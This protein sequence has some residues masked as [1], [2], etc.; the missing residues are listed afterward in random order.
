MAS[1][2]ENHQPHS[3]TYGATTAPPPTPAAQT[4]CLSTNDAADTLSHFLHR[5]PPSL[6][7]PPRLS[8]RTTCPPSISFSPQNTSFLDPYLS[9]FSQLGFFQLTNHPIPSQLALSAESESLSLFNLSKTQKHQSFSNTWPLGYDEGDDNNNMEGGPIESFCFDSSCSTESTEV[10]SSTQLSL[11]S[12]QKFTSELEKVGTD[13]VEALSSAMG[14]SKRLKEKDIQFSSLMWVSE[15]VAGNKQMISGRFYPYII[16]LQYQ[17]T[18][19]KYSVLTDSGWSSV[20]PQVDSVLVTVGDIA[21]VWS[22]GKLK[23]VRGRPVATSGNDNSRFITMSLLVTLPTDTTVTIS[24]FLP[25]ISSHANDSANDEGQENDKVD[26][27]TQE[28][29]IF[30]TFSFED[31]AWRVY[32][33]RFLFKD[34]LD[35]YL[36]K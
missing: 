23:K 1:S 29:M 30:D 21:Q 3:A 32:H 20:S 4:N 16:A 8:P 35:R 17:I 6:S 12:L 2:A 19:R 27:V 9:S 24:P 31:Y 5:L 10:T 15:G 28:K 25:V 11:A 36:I 14:F 22:N 34:P 13:V 33:E 26:K 7:L 18:C